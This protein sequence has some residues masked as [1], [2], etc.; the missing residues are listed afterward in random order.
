MKKKLLSIISC[1]IMFTCILAGCGGPKLKGG[2]SSSDTIYGNGGVAV[3]KG[4]YLYFANGYSTRKVSENGNKYGKEKLSAIY[5]V[6]LNE[7]GLVN[8][9]E[10]G[11]P[12]GAQRLAGQIA[13]FK[14]SGIYIFGDYIYYAT[15]KTLKV[16][17]DVGTE[18]LLEGLLSFERVKLDGSDHDTIYSISTLGDDLDYSFAQVGKNVCLTVLNNKTLRT[19]LVDINGGKPTKK[20]LATNVTDV[21]FPQVE[22]IAKG[23]KVSEVDSYVYYVKTATVAKDGYDGKK[24]AK[25][26]LTGSKA[27]VTIED[28]TA[29][30]LEAVKNSRIYYKENS[31]LYSTID[32]ENAT[33]Y[34][35]QDLTN[36]I[37]NQ[38]SFDTDMG[39]IAVV[40]NSLVYYR[41]VNFYKVL[42]TVDSETTI[43]PLYA[44]NNQ[45]YYNLGDNILYS[46]E[47]VRNSYPENEATIEGTIHSS[48]INLSTN[49]TTVFDYEQN[50]I[51]YY[52]KVEDSNQ[53]YSYL[54]FVKHFEK[55]E[56]GE[57]FE[58]FIGKLHSKDIKEDSEK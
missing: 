28:N 8:T 9:D 49:E 44:E 2:P 48:N 7:Q 33:Q 3:R 52:D 10:D 24:L 17:S 50:Y 4:D 37:I 1:L 35:H 12:V 42:L 47:I 22:D 29:V 11:N 34:S 19:V 13:G 57:T 26:K 56:E 21:A 5:R 55:N 41:D 27:E 45:V 46:K 53:T 6:K 31:L 39:I 38:D 15:P 40:N 51:F 20:T 58:Q 43:T 30:S 25:R 36:Y 23:Y 14:D 18:E 16:K 32:F 54:H